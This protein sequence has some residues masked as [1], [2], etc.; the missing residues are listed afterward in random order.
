MSPE[1]A[2]TILR[3]STMA[4]VILIMGFISYEMLSMIS[5]C[6]SN[7]W[8]AVIQQL[9]LFQES[10]L[11]SAV[12]KRDKLVVRTVH[13]LLMV[14]ILGSRHIISCEKPW[15]SALISLT[16]SFAI[17]V[18]GCYEVGK[19]AK[20]SGRT[21][22]KFVEIMCT[23]L[24][25]VASIAGAAFVIYEIG[26]YSISD[27]SSILFVWAIHLVVGVIYL[28]ECVFRLKDNDVEINKTQ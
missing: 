22:V 14:L 15:Q 25:I 18:G 1:F 21:I 20:G 4:I 19:T 2:N 10:Y 12:L 8:L 13:S 26:D 7:W 16:G 23:V 5:G 27:M 6:H 11:F 17:L 28:T 24:V 3:S 9:I